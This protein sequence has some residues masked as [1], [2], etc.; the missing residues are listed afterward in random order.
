M[1]R[2]AICNPRI[3]LTTIAEPTHS[4]RGWRFVQHLGRPS[5]SAI[6]LYA[7]AY[8]SNSVQRPAAHGDVRADMDLRS[9]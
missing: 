5:V 8:S 1:Q 4:Q 6:S 7:P 9:K 2:T 3:R